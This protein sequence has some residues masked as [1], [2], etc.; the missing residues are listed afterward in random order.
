MLPGCCKEAAL[1]YRMAVAGMVGVALLS[2]FVWQHHLFVRG[3]NA[4]LRPFFMLSTELISVP[5]AFTFLCSWGR[6]GSPRIRFTVRCS[7][8]LAWGS[9]FL[10]GGLTGVYLSDVPSDVATHGTFFLDG[11][12]PLHDHGPRLHVLRRDLL[13]LPKMMGIEL[14]QLLG[15]STSG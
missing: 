2:F 6:S 12:L 3:M 4:D 8:A 5:T 10:V 11:P 1:G 14:N 9:N 7:S 15:R 13:L